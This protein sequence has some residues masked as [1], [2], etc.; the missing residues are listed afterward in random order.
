MKSSTANSV[1]TH[2][3]MGAWAP[4]YDLLM[5]VITLGREK[6]LRKLTVNVAGVKAGD[7][8]LE[9]GCGTGTLSLA[10]QETV[11]QFGNVH[12]IDAAPEMIE[13]AQKKNKRAGKSVHFKVGLIDNIPYSDNEFDA[14]MCSFMI[15]H[16]SKDVRQRG[17]KEIFRVLK[18]NGKLLIVDILK[19]EGINEL[20]QLMEEAGFIKTTAEK[21]N[22]SILFSRLIFVQ[23][24]VYKV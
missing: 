3:Q 19:Q 7:N 20:Q 16:M 6:E 13:R 15:F 14:V 11:G 18:Q 23:G 2:G 8:V 10:I 4:Y 24:I 9:A 21:R 5:K 1:E 22:L 17:L 12:A